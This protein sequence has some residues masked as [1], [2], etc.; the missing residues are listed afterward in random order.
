MFPGEL[1]STVKEHLVEVGDYCYEIG[2]KKTIL[3]RKKEQSCCGKAS[4]M[5]YRNCEV[6]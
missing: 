2:N 4:D 3:W 1:L 6:R 5:R